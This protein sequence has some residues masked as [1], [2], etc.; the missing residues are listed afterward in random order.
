VGTPGVVLMGDFRNFTNYNPFT[1][2]YADGSN[3]SLIRNASGATSAIP[4]SLVQEAI[5]QRMRAVAEP[6]IATDTTDEL[7]AS[8]RVAAEPVRRAI[9]AD[10][11]PEKPP[12]LLAFYLPQFHPIPENDASWGKGF[13]EWRNVGPSRAYFDGQQQPRVPTELGYYD[14]R[15]PL[16]MEQQ[17]ELAR[18]HGIHGFCY[19]YYWFEGRRLLHIP[20]DNM[21]KRRAPDFPFCFC[22]AN[23]NWTR[24]WDGAA[25]QILVPQNH[26]PEDDR[27]FIHA[28]IPAFE[29]KR[30][31]RVDGKPVLLVYRTE[32]FPSP[33]ATADLWRN[34][35]RKAGIGDLYLVRCEGFD[36]FTTPAEIGFDAAY[37]VPSF[38]LPNTVRADTTQ[39]NVSPDFEGQIFDYDKIVRLFNERPDVSYNRHRGV[40]LAWDNTPRYGKKA[41]VFH[42]VTEAGYERWLTNAIEYTNRRFSGEDRLVFI[43]A[44]NEWAEGSY[45]EP[46]LHRGRGFLEATRRVVNRVSAPYSLLDAGV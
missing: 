14:L 22:W 44:W 3:A 38:Y 24:R 25:K 29:D 36:P 16:V 9:D 33:A 1:G 43:N 27:R 23:E 32:L 28:L 39:L 37:E 34:E 7:F 10:L 40:M 2:G 8:A 26:S 11:G 6:D 13:T 42:N 20:I 30:Y 31:I 5:A 17:A 12:R 19:Y 4:L 18:E 45:L 35:A 15:L 41:V 21:L 46:D